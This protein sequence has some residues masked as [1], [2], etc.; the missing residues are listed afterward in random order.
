MKQ[1]QIPVA[2]HE[3]N[4]VGRSECARP[5]EVV[6]NSQV[7]DNS[8]RMW[9]RYFAY[10]R[11]GWSPDSVVHLARKFYHGPLFAKRIKRLGGPAG[12]YLE[13]GVGTAES[14][15]KLRQSTGA[16][17]FGVDKTAF[18]CDVAKRGAAECHIVEADALA[19][20]F[21]DASFDVVYSL[22]LLEHFDEPQ[23]T[24]LFREHARVARHV[25]LLHVP[26]RVPH[27]QV[28]LWINR[29]VCGRTGVWADEE[30]FTT[31]GFREKFP[32]LPFRSYFDVAAGAMTYWFVVKP[33]DVLQHV[34][35][36][37]RSF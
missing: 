6:R 31:A 17:C 23:Q 3:K 5:V 2:R 33:E 9:N 8:E 16:E 4:N 26:A 27:H 19:L 7:H 1:L 30:L 13:I 29:T 10:C 12:S 24:C 22:G 28:L 18:A 37:C 36:P 35:T 14:L 34:V 32:G 20:P 15:N 25:V 21:R 11:G